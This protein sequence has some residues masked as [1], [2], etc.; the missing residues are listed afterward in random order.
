MTGAPKI[1]AI[2]VAAQKEKLNRGI[3]SGAIGYFFGEEI[4]LSVVIRTLVLR[5]EKFEFQ[6]GGA[7]TFDSDAQAEL[8]ETFSKAKGIEE[9]LGINVGE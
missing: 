3:Y 4:N 9:L 1:K 6:T 5:G 7:I 2:E 8:A